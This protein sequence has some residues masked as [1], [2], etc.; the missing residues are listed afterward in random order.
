[1]NK[2]YKIDISNIKVVTD[3]VQLRGVLGLLRHYRRYVKGFSRTAQPLFNL[4]KNDKI[5]SK[6]VERF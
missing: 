5:I 3:L 4:L 1:M 6:V 2:G